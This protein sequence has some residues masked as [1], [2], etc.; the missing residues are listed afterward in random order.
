MAKK[1]TMRWII[2]TG[3]QIFTFLISTARLC[4]QAPEAPNVNLV[5]PTLGGTQFWADQRLFQQYR[6]QKNVVTNHFRLLDP[7]DRRLAW[8]SY[9]ACDAALERIIADR[10][11]SPMKGHAVIVLHGLGSWRARMESLAEY[12]R[13]NG[14]YQ[15]FN[16]TYPSTQADIAAHAEMLAAIIDRLQGIESVD[17]VAHS[18]GNI[19]VRRYLYEVQKK[20]RR[21]EESGSA[22]DKKKSRHPE[23]H[24]FVMLGPP[25]H[26][27]SAAEYFGDK[28]VFKS[29]IGDAVKELGPDWPEFEKRLA[30][31]NF[32]FG[33][34]AGGKKGEKGINPLFREDNDGVL[35]V[36][37]TKLLGARDFVVLPALHTFM[38]DNDEVQVC[39]LNFLKHG[40]FYSEKERKPIER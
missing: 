32:E 23:F 39:T 21:A 13:V 4:G 2:R 37:T 31:P 26:G 40:Y 24:R 9:E 30:T 35:S 8:G 33:V 29:V 14:G 27:A 34:I 25:N 6:I 15:V 12:L 18:M 38:M 3:F 17:F 10:R 11:L 7:K 1:T 5:T 22:A 19:V 36:E 16:L 20:E 28:A